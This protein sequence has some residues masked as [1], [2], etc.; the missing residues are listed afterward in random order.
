MKKKEKAPATPQEREAACARELKAVLAKHN[1]NLIPEPYI[2]RGA[3]A[4]RHRIVANEN[5][6]V[7]HQ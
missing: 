5:L 6:H 1:C 7:P 3:I 2:N 4:A